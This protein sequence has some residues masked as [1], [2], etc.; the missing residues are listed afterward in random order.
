[1]EYEWKFASAQETAQAI[2]QTYDWYDLEIEDVQSKPVSVKD[3]FANYL[4]GR[5]PESDTN[6]AFFQRLQ[7]LVTELAQQ[8]AE[9]SPE[10]AGAISACV[11]E[12]MLRPKDWKAE[13]NAK[14][15]MLVGVEQ[16]AGPLLPYLERSELQRIRDD[17]LRH[18]PKR[19]MYPKQQ[20]LLK[21]ME[22]LLRES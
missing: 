9:E 21:E 8:L 2:F 20:A 19:K 1:M 22:R 10:E 13:G 5:R 11:V 12:R 15:L 3:Y 6:T 4:S 18:N 16:L 17:Y 7:Q 14:A